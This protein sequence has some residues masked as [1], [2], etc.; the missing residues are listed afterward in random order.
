ML[1]GTLSFILPVPFYP[2][3]QGCLLDSRGAGL[4]KGAEPARL[5][6]EPSSDKGD[7]RLGLG[8]EARRPPGSG[9]PVS[10]TLQGSLPCPGPAEPAQLSL[11]R[12]QTLVGFARETGNFCSAASLDDFDTPLS[13]GREEGPGA[14]QAWRSHGSAWGD[15]QG[16]LA[17]PR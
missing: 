17:R 8:L 16:G 2:F 1:P 3:S 15:G 5:L 14:P 11:S 4:V 6:P 13:G 7:N 9:M 10:Q 12:T